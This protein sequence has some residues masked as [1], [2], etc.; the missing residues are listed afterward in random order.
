MI[1]Q[2]PE[3]WKILIGILIILLGIS[4]WIAFGIVEKNKVNLYKD[5]Q[6]KVYKK[7]NPRFKGTY[8]EAKLILP[9]SQR[10]RLTEIQITGLEQK[11]IGL[12]NWKGIVFKFFER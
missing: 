2:I 6:L 5:Q 4:I 3:W 11:I 9:W 12:N 10:F 1:T 7:Q 8:K